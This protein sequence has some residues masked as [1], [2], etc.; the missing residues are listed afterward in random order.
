MR[1]PRFNVGGLDIKPSKVNTKYSRDK[2][3]SDALKV[4]KHGVAK[5]E[6]TGEHTEV[7]DMLDA[8]VERLEKSG[9]RTG[10][11][12]LAAAYI[13][14]A[15]QLKHVLTTI[16]ADLHAIRFRNGRSKG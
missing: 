9:P 16:E 2:T 1:K 8:V 12:K 7:L 6:Q 10:D 5:L 4:I 15:K 14:V 3:R 13:V 11:K